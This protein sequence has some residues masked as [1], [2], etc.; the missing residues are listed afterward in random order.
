[1]S[2]RTLPFFVQLHLERELLGFRAVDVRGRDALAERGDEG[3]RLHRRSGLALAVGRQVER[4]LVVVVAADHREH[5]AGRVVDHDDRGGG[6]DPADVVVDGLLGLALEVEVERRLDVQ[7]AAERLAGAVVVDDLLAQ[8]RGEVGRL[9]LLARGLDVLRVGQRRADAGDLVVVLVLGD[10]ALLEHLREHGVAALEREVRVGARRVGLG[11]GD[12]PGE[13]R[14][15]VG[16]EL[17]RA[18]VALAAAAV[19]GL[20]EVRLRGGLDPVRALAEVDR[21][22]VLGEDLVLRPLAL[23]VVRQ[24]RLAELLE[25]RPALLRLERVLDELLGDRRRALHGVAGDDVLDHGAGD[26]HDVDPAVLVEALVLDRDDRL[27]HRRRDVRRLDEDPGLV[28]G[29]R[30]ER[31]VVAVGDDRVL[32]G[33]VLLAVLELGQVGGD[34]HHDPEDERDEGEHAEPEHDH[35]QPQLL[36]LRR[37][38]R[39]LV[40]TAERAG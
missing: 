21:V 8:P 26:A 22:Q 33:E 39:T 24:R 11:R 15:F 27:L 4:R 37:G 31:P 36:Q 13:Q 9:G 18:A 7:S 40:A 3:E 20:A 29:E 28:T 10:R 23:E 19:V 38:A 14:G 5:A 25:D 1:M 32:R 16:E 30:G 6:L 17:G 2:G 35:E 34:R 12:D